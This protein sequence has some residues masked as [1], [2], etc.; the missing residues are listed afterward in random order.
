MGR[1]NGSGVA[2]FPRYTESELDPAVHAEI[3]LESAR[4]EARI[5]VLEIVLALFFGALL[6]FRDPDFR[7]VA[8]FAL[9]TVVPLLVDSALRRSAASK[10]R[11]RGPA[12]A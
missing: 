12:P 3:L 8:L 11:G 10:V 4:N 6:G 9:L 1:R 7:P 2:G 5:A